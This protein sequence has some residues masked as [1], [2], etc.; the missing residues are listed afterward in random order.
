MYKLP[1]LHHMGYANQA[2][3][4]QQKIPSLKKILCWLHGA[5][6]GEIKGFVVICMLF[7]TT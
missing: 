4:S 7:A 6:L 1:Q 3:V 2:V 5:V